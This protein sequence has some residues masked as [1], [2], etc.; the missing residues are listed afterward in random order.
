MRPSNMPQPPLALAAS[1]Q[2]HENSGVDSPL[3]RWRSLAAAIGGG[4][5]VAD[6]VSSFSPLVSYRLPLISIGRSPG[7]RLIMI[8]GLTVGEFGSSEPIVRP[9]EGVAPLWRLCSARGFRCPT[10]ESPSPSFRSAD[11][12]RRRSTPESSRGPSSP[13]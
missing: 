12:H 13:T 5:E 2:Y 6:L 7:D 11:P 8:P 3:R 9:C 10:L 4:G 1:T